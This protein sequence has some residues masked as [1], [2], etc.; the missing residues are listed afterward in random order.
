MRPITDFPGY[1]AGDDG[2]IYSTL[3]RH[4]AHKQ[5]SS[6]HKLK[7]WRLWDGYQRVALRRDGRSFHRLVHCLVCEAFHGKRP[8][9]MDACHG[10]GGRQDNTPA[11][12]S[13]GSRSKNM[14]EDRIR[15]GTFT[16]GG[17]S[18]ASKLNP[19]KVRWA[20]TVRKEGMTPEEIAAKLGVCRDT[21]MRALRGQGTWSYVK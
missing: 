17:E 3:V 5:P 9:R 13:W 14:K 2:A 21:I 20:R 15:D 6:P 16:S 8:P 19:D 12:L 4:S 7:S 18:H 11:N 1:F 10:P